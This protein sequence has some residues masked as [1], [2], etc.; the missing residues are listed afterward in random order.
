MLLSG[1]KLPLPPSSIPD[2]FGGELF[3]N[4]KKEEPTEEFLDQWYSNKVSFK[5]VVLTGWNSSICDRSVEELMPSV[6][7]YFS[8][9]TQEL[10]CSLGTVIA[11]TGGAELHLSS[12]RHCSTNTNTA[13]SG[14]F[15]NHKRKQHCN[16][17]QVVGNIFA[18]IVNLSISVGL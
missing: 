17:Q 16:S 12:P 14:S 2:C 5:N 3:C 15:I 7:P 11:T 10:S 13:Q 6:S 8:L 18:F 1:Q 9:K 4:F